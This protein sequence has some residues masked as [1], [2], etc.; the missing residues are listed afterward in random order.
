M[1][2][3]IVDS[4]VKIIQKDPVV[5]IQESSTGYDFFHLS[6]KKTAITHE[7]NHTEYNDTE[8]KDHIKTLEEDFKRKLFEVEK[9]IPAE[10]VNHSSGIPKENVEFLLQSF[11]K[12]FDYTQAI[13]EEV[14]KSSKNFESEI[15][16]FIK[17][18]ELPEK[19]IEEHHHHT[20]ETVKE[21]CVPEEFYQR[22]D[23]KIKQS[24]E[25]ELNENV[26]SPPMKDMEIRNNELIVKF[27]D[28]NERSLGKIRHESLEFGGY[29]VE[30]ARGQTGLSAYQLAV[31]LGFEGSHQQWI[32]SLKF[33][34][35]TLN[36]LPE[37]DTEVP[38]TEIVIKQ[39]DSF[40]RMSVIDFLS[41]Y[42]VGL[43]SEPF[44][45]TLTVQGN[46]I[47]LT[48][49]PQ[50]GKAG[51][52]N[53]GYAR[54]IDESGTWFETPLSETQDPKVFTLDEGYEWDGVPVIVQYIYASFSIN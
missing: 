43:V 40:T 14:Q 33:Q 52:S 5:T 47:T 39:G 49:E 6:G 18:I 2:N 34:V 1:K 26:Q 45:E 35:D 30:G 20:T 54:H 50:N 25:V 4:L 24:L 22:I 8:L 15:L 41:F 10:V 7:K 29:G 3:E 19:V 11:V 51:I 37:A 28:G 17:T 16:E 13:K 9:K 44:I 23:E 53:F 21:Q 38:W 31:K 32:D 46:S 12:Q 42:D 36:Q 48:H 27:M